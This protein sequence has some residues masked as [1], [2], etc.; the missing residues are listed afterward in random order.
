MNDKKGDICRCPKYFCKNIEY[1]FARIVENPRI[2]SKKYPKIILIN[3]DNFNHFH[4]NK[5]IM[6]FK[7][8]DEDGVIESEI[9]KSI[10]LI[11]AN[12]QDSSYNVDNE[13][14]KFVSFLKKTTIEELEE[15][16]KGDEKYMAATR[17]VKDLSLDPEF[18]GYYDL[19]EAHKEE[20]EDMRITALEEGMEQKAL[21]TAKKMLIK[22]K[23]INE[24]QEFTDLSIEKIKELKE[25]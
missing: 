21:E 17:T 10:H 9:F 7:I 15:E 18:S 22:G 13:I 24:I 23:D 16:F 6:E 12:F 4:T 5:P 11:L 8:R 25:E 1:T 20:L 19:E 2:N 14:K 3:I